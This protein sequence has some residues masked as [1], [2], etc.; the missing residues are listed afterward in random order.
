MGYRL[1]AGLI[2]AVAVILGACAAAPNTRELVVLVPDQDGTT[3][4][5]VVT[6]PQGGSS[7]LSKPYAMALLERGDR[8]DTPPVARDEVTKLFS[9]AIA[10]QPLRPI[11]FLLYF[12][13]DTDEYTPESSEAFD[14]V[15]AE[16]ARRKV[17]EIAVIGHTD[18]VG[19]LEYND[20]LSLRRAERVRKDFVDRG[21]PTSAINVAGRGEREPIVP[22]ADEAYEPRN[23]R[24]EINVR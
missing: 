17:A 1:R 5:V 2:A 4:A 24:V 11:S 22:T 9:H 23:R 8:V 13:L 19:S 21:I 12:Q 18:R 16:V 14:K 15:F 3:G 7:V 10:A 6:H 20:T